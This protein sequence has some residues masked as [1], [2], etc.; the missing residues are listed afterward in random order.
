MLEL[1]A[2]TSNILEPI[3]HGFFTRKGGVS[4]GLYEGLNCG[5]GSS[6]FK[7]AVKKNRLAVC[8]KMGI[9]NGMLMSVNQVHSNKVVTLL[10]PTQKIIAADAMITDK[11]FMSLAILTA[12]CQP[13][14]FADLEARIIGAAHAGWKGTLSGIL[15]GTI[16]SMV[17]LGAKRCN[18]RAVIGPSISQESYEVGAE[19]VD[20][21]IESST[22][23]EQYFKSLP[24]NKF[25]FD[26][27]GL[28]LGQLKKSGVIA[29][30]LNRCTYLE[31]ELFYS[32]RRSIHKKEPDYGRFIS[33][34]KL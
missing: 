11:P 3:S 9:K 20:K 30:R 18:I 7:D 34:I 2:L 6:D 8:E 17:K 32:Y 22:K 10:K 25:L 14:L 19:F 13:V 5:F 26:L 28:A 24:N 16:S 29:E 12:D 21:F 31:S 33:V 27:T 15:E 1:E 4:I 23:N